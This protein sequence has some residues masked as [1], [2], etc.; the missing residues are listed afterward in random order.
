M[1]RPLPPV[2]V[3]ERARIE[4]HNQMMED[5]AREH[6]VIVWRICPDHYI[7]CKLNGRL[8]CKTKE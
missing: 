8:Q 5:A 7:P 1:S 4:E 2:F 6:D 3:N